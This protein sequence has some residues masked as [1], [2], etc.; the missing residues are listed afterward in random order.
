[1]KQDVIKKIDDFVRKNKRLPRNDEY[2]MKFN[3]PSRKAVSRWLGNPGSYYKTK[4]AELWQKREEEN[5]ANR[6]HSPRRYTKPEIEKMILRYIE[7]NGCIPNDKSFTKDN[8]LPS[9]EAAKRYLGNLKEY[10][11]KEFPEYTA[12]INKRYMSDTSNFKYTAEMV[13][14]MLEDFIKKEKRKPKMNDFKS[15]NGLPSYETAK[16]HLGEKIHK[17]CK[18]HSSVKESEIEQEA[19]NEQNGDE[20]SFGGM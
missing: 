20:M 4:Y 19:V 7:E 3:M 12:E 17:Y 1:M 11:N 2:T 13:E 14:K 5:R 8:G 16:R 10:Y 9:I 6:N 15:K 18:L